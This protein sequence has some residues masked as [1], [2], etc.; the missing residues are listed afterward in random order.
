MPYGISDDLWRKLPPDDQAAV[1]AGAKGE[2]AP[3]IGG[4]APVATLAPQ[5]NLVY[6][7]PAD[8][9][10]R[11]PSDDQAAVRAESMGQPPPAIG[12]YAPT[13]ANPAPPP[14][15]TA[16][17]S[18][19][20]GPTG[21]YPAATTVT[22]PEKASATKPNPSIGWTLASNE[23]QVGQA[24]ARVLARHA[25]GDAPGTGPTPVQPQTI[26]GSAASFIRSTESFVPHPYN[27]AD[28]NATIGYGHLLHHGPVTAADV[29]RWGTITRAEGLRLFQ[30]DA[31]HAAAVVRRY[32][33][34][35]LSQG[36]L[37]ALVDFV[38][39]EGEGNFANSTLLNELNAGRFNN[40]PAQFR[41]WVYGGGRVL[42]G[43]VKR[44]EVEIAMFARGVYPS[45][46]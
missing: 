34:V 38:F 36:Q 42:G 2:P 24:G 39:N 14:N 30:S 28:G 5:P 11:L 1:I 17:G 3:A 29:A 4:Y 44:R 9:W 23:A 27:D 19:R 20:S 25:P 35:P 21:D 18:S 6:G 40:V 22:M 32:V 31:N 15:L 13:A 33:T 16:P 37:D 8:L 12:G 46:G 10:R 45:N 7:I 43:L 41:R 26:S